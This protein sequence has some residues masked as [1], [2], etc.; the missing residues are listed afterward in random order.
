M[1][2]PPKITLINLTAV[3]AALVILVVIIVTSTAVLLQQSRCPNLQQSRCP[4]LASL[5]HRTA[6]VTTRTTSKL[7][8][9]I[10]DAVMLP[11]ATTTTRQPVA[12]HRSD[13]VVSATD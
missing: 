3:S 6:S 12:V 11:A 4:N 10:S 9:A 1:S 13:D 7:V 5:E 8:A 2:E